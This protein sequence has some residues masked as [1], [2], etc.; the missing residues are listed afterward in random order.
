VWGLEGQ[1]LITISRFEPGLPESLFA[2]GA[3]KTKK[4]TQKKEKKTRK[5]SASSKAKK[6]GA[7]AHK[8]NEGG[9]PQH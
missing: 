4:E 2:P 9:L 6:G 5:S 8:E 7:F 1:Q 3:A